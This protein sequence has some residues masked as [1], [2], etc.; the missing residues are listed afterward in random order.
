MIVSFH[1]EGPDP[2]V[3]R[4]LEIFQSKKDI[5]GDD[6]NDGFRPISEK[7]YNAQTTEEETNERP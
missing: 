2:L 1:D 4:T 5:V 7:D 6:K 3:K